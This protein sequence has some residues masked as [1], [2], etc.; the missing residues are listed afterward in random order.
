[1]HA[2]AQDTTKSDLDTLDI[3]F[4]SV[5]IPAEFPGGEQGWNNFL[6]KNMNR[7]TPTKNHAPV[8][9]Y[10]VVVS[11]LIDKEGQV[12]EVD[13]LEDPGYGTAQDVI[14]V[15]RKSPRWKPA[16]QNGKNV[17]YRQKQKITYQVN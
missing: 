2:T 8:G 7:R 14:R 15:L 5:Q 9:I 1:M 16:M 13:I 4:T 11:F 6:V 3:E 17:I 12:G 10:S